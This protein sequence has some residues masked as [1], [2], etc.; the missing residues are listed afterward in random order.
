LSRIKYIIFRKGPKKE[1]YKRRRALDTVEQEKHYLLVIEARQPRITC[2]RMIGD[3]AKQK[4][5]V[6]RH[7][8]CVL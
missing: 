5:T 1:R 6:R 7:V 3:P 4:F 8:G 2:T